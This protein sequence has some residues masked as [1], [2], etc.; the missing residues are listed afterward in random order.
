MIRRHDNP[1]TYQVNTTRALYAVTLE[2][3]HNDRNGNGRYK[4]N[5]IVLQ[6]HGEPEPVRNYYT[7]QFTFTGH[8]F[9]EQGEAQFIVDHYESILEG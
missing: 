3:Q 9:G 7:T 6:V 5:V 8:C 1:T 4:A 2:R